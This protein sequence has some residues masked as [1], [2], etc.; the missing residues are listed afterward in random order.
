MNTIS[1][2]SECNS[3]AHHDY[4]QVSAHQR[5]VHAIGARLV[6]YRINGLP[7]QRGEILGMARMAMALGAIDAATHTELLQLLYPIGELHPATTSNTPTTAL[8]PVAQEAH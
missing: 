8:V 5:A 3:G 1:P 7:E 2:R 4:R 6:A